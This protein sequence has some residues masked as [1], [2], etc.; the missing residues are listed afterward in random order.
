LPY[1]FTTL[2]SNLIEKEEKKNQRW[3][4]HVT[5][6]EY[7]EKIQNGISQKKKILKTDFYCHAY[8]SCGSRIIVY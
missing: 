2:R 1:E 6:V 8:Q 5:L 4:E 7:D 3:I